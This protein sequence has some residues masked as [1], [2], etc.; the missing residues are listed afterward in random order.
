MGTNFYFIPKM[1]DEDVQDILLNAKKLAESKDYSDLEELKNKV[2]KVVT[3]I[4]LGKI[5]AGWQ[6]LWNH[7]NLKYYNPDLESI[8]KF[9]KES[10]GIIKDEYN[11]VFSYEQFFE[12]IGDW[13]YED[14]DH[15]TAKIFSEKYADGVLP[16]ISKT[17][18]VG[19]K[20]YN[21]SRG[22]FHINDLR[23]ADVTEFS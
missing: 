16:N 15:M 7:N 21:S 2:H 1:S 10:D 3:E 8:Q 12:E 9:L 5:S 14:D 23:F 17:L 13:L 18:K 19:N 22:E 6:F 4:H 20:V 11:Q